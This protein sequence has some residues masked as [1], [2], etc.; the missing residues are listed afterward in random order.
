MADSDAAVPRAV[1]VPWQRLP[2]WVERYDAR[3]PGTS[4][5]FGCGAATASSPDGT[6]V[7][8]ALP[9]PTDALTS[10]E[11]IAVHLSKPWRL[12]VVLVRRGGFAVASVVGADLEL[13]KV[14]RRHVQGKT[15]AGGWSQQRFAN[16]RANQARQAFDAAAEYAAEILLPRAHRLDQV[17]TGGDRQAVAAV[18]A[19]P[20]LKPLAARPQRWLGG[21]ADPTRAVLDEAV[22]TARAVKVEITDG[23]GG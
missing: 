2:G 9:F 13:V 11:A 17:V 19:Q 20:R 6:R 3:H 14:S 15:K 21:V 7:H 1:Q 16:R 12:G 8:V 5:C 4:W 10:W 23:P 22:T 18:F